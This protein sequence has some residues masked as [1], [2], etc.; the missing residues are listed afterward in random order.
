MT[1]VP[2]ERAGSVA[3]VTGRLAILIFVALLAY[4]PP[5]IFYLAEDIHK[6]W[7]W[8]TILLANS[9]IIIRLLLGTT[10]DAGW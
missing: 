9:P 4:F 7:I 6:R 8:L 10:G 3:E 1:F 2:F 5:R